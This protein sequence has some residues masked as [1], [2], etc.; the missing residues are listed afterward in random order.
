MRV[1]DTLGNG[2]CKT[3]NPK[4]E[5]C[6]GR[7]LFISQNTLGLNIAKHLVKTIGF[8]WAV[9]GPPL[10]LAYSRIRANPQVCSVWWANGRG[11]VSIPGDEH[12]VY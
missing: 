3:A 11:L 4:R 6:P 1:I 5:R 2:N 7:A 8:L 10:I 9:E 12:N